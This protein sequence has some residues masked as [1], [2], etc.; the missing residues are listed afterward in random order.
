MKYFVTIKVE[1]QIVVEADSEQ[2]AV[3]E[4]LLSFDATA[5]DPEIIDV[6]SNE[7]DY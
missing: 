6:W 7:D 3:K 1:E 2:E 5:H 4:A